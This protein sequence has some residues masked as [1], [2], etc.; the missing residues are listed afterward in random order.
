MRIKPLWGNS[1]HRGPGSGCVDFPGFYLKYLI[2]WGLASKNGSN[3]IDRLAIVPDCHKIRTRKLFTKS[4]KSSVHNEV[5]SFCGIL[6]WTNMFVW[7]QHLKRTRGSLTPSHL[8]STFCLDKNLHLSTLQFFMTLDTQSHH[9]I[10]LPFWSTKIYSTINSGLK[11]TV[12]Q[13][14]TLSG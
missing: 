12:H 2:W 14:T 4:A 5:V 6:P 10:H 7:T 9:Q 8:L 11:R 3:S 1:L 13:N